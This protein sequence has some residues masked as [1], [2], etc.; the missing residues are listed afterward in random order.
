MNN[1]TCIFVS[2]G[3]RQ[4]LFF[5]VQQRSQWKFL[6]LGAILALCLL[7]PDAESLGLAVGFRTFSVPANLKNST[8][9]EFTGRPSEPGCLPSRI[10]FPVSMRALETGMKLVWHHCNDLHLIS[11]GL[12]VGCYGLPHKIL[13]NAYLITQQRILQNCSPL[14]GKHVSKYIQGILNNPILTFHKCL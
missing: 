7:V 2:F 9:Q 11:C 1:K 12:R 14:S 3:A 10:C 4:W 8:S 6:S 13:W 5:W